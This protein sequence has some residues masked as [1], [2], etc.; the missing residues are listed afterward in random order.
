MIHSEELKSACLKDVRETVRHLLPSGVEKSGE[1]IIGGTDGEKGKSMRVRVEGEKSGVWIDFSTG[2]S[3][4]IIKLW[5]SV[6][7]VQFKEAAVQIAA[8]FNLVDPDA[9]SK[10]TQNWER[11][12]REMGTGTEHD[13]TELQAQRKLPTPSG[14]IA[15]RE[16]GH[17]F[18]GPVMD[19]PENDYDNWRAHHSWIITDSFR[20]GAQSRRMDGQ[21]YHDGQKSKTV[22][23]TKGSWTIGIAGSAH[24][25]VA[26]TE[27]SPD[28]LAAYTAVAMLGLLG[29]IQ[30][31]TILGSSQNIH[32]DALPLFA[33]RTVWMFPHDDE[34]YAGLKGAI[35][36][37]KSLKSVG[38]VTVPFD[39][40]P[41]PGV[42]DLNDFLTAAHETSLV[43]DGQDWNA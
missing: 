32:H 11:L 37:E 42:K 8:H 14:L 41:Y 36:W 34:N 2:E 16:R 26:F 23:G 19:G 5:Q 43:N 10:S 30:P 21:P 1:W 29:R 33:N 20:R 24:P 28:F 12:Q 17:L 15:A 27:G 40:T 6:R 38:A 31:V 7:G 13:I 18:F 35:R 22:H 39:F 25:D 3:G 4:D 9:E